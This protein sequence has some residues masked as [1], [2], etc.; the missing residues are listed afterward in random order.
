VPNPHN[1]LTTKV[2]K[3]LNIYVVF[4]H[5]TMSNSDISLPTSMAFYI[6]VQLGWMDGWGLTAFAFQSI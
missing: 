5:D 2:R 3:W 4:E 1:G 6:A